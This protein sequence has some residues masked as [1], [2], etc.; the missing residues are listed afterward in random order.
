MARQFDFRLPP[1]PCA[2]VALRASQKQHEPIMS[3]TKTPPKEPGL[4]WYRDNAGLSVVRLDSNGDCWLVLG[5][6]MVGGAELLADNGE[7][8]LPKLTP[9]PID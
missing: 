4:Y 8:W 6:D 2:R 1:R 5:S 3:W 7:W 9:P